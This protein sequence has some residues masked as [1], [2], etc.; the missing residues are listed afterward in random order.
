MERPAVHRGCHERAC[1]RA[2]ASRQHERLE[3]QRA[4]LKTN[5][6]HLGRTRRES[7]GEARGLTVASRAPR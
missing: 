2:A 1:S 3:E 6:I 4:R 5:V 7:R